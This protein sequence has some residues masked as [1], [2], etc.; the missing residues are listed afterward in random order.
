LSVVPEAFTQQQVGGAPGGFSAGASGSGK[1]REPGSLLKEAALLLEATDLSG[2]NETLKE[3]E[4]A[5]AF[6][7]GTDR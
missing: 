3:A 6:R 2:A 7:D 1:R 4:K 5:L